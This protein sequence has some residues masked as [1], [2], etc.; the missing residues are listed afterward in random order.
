MVGVR[1]WRTSSTIVGLGALSLFFV[2]V[3][4]V[5]GRAAGARRGGILLLVEVVVLVGVG[6]RHLATVARVRE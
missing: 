2:L 3:F 4:V 5:G 1:P 6:V